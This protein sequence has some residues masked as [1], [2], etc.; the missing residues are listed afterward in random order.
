MVKS[1]SPKTSPTGSPAKVINKGTM[2]TM[3]NKGTVVKNVHGLPVK[4][5]YKNGKLVCE[6][7]DRYD[8][9]DIIECKSVFDEQISSEY[10]DNDDFVEA[11]NEEMNKLGGPTFKTV[12]CGLECGRRCYLCLDVPIDKYRAMEKLHYAVCYVHDFVDT[13]MHDLICPDCF[14][15]EVRE[16]NKCGHQEVMECSEPCHKCG[17]KEE[18][19]DELPSDTE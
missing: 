15:T 18:T 6:G 7:I 8:H 16:C 9:K 2:K 10:K 19:E 13:D 1:V 14:E 12:E 3:P 17:H 4:F 5:S 11:W